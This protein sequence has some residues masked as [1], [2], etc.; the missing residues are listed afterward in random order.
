MTI[1]G[2]RLTWMGKFHETL[3]QNEEL[4]VVNGQCVL[5]HVALL[6]VSLKFIFLKGHMPRD[7]QE[8]FN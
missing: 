6:C 5:H 2:D 8:R 3:A 7:G 4:R 1:P